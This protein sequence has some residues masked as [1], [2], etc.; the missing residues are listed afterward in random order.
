MSYRE[1]ELGKRPKTKTV[2]CGDRERMKLCEALCDWAETLRGWIRRRGFRDERMNMSDGSNDVR[3]HD[4]ENSGVQR[5]SID[6]HRSSFLS[7]VFFL[8][9][10]RAHYGTPVTLCPMR[11]LL[12]N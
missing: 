12:L 2:A 10:S 8:R 3:M 6:K 4:R 1:S 9:Y 7:R 11:D 5:I